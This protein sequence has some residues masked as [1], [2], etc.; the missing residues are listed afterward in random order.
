M[1]SVLANPDDKR[2]YSII[3]L[4]I[5]EVEKEWNAWDEMVEH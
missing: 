5:K 2:T 4:E 3:K 1:L